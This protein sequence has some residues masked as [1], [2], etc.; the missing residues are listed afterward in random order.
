[1]PPSSPLSP[2]ISAVWLTALRNVDARTALI[3]DHPDRTLFKGY[4]LPDPAIFTSGDAKPDRVQKNMIAWLLICRA[5]ITYTTSRT[6]RTSDKEVSMPQPA[7]WKTFLVKLA[8]HFNL[9]C[10]SPAVSSSTAVVPVAGFA[11]RHGAPSR[12]GQPAAKVRK[13]QRSGKIDQYEID[14]SF[15]ANLRP[16]LVDVMW[17]GEIVKNR[18]TLLAGNL[19]LPLWIVP[20]IVWELFEQNFRLELL[21]LDRCIVSQ[22]N[23]SVVEHVA[24]EDMVSAV[25]PD[26]LI[27]MYKLPLKDQGLGRACLAATC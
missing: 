14:E 4:A 22:K 17:D 21:A 24:R 18:D 13:V 16:G 10:A 26:G 15:T 11:G 9:D 23:M 12:G 7:N 19:T 8:T 6:A 2:N 27:I 3:L 5:W 20:E 25:F 1:M